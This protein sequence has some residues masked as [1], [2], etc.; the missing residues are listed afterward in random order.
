MPV[1]VNDRVIFLLKKIPA[2]NVTGIFK[3]RSLTMTYSHMGNPH[4]TI[5]DEPF[6]C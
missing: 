1:M 5:G 4:T 6:H 3:V 2:T